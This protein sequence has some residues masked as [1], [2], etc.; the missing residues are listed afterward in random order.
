[1]ETNRMIFSISFAFVALCVTAYA[2]VHYYLKTRHRER[3]ALIEAGLDP[4]AFKASSRLPTF[5]MMVSI[6]LLGIAFAIGTATLLHAIS[7]Y[8]FEE[9]PHF[10]LIAFPFFLAIS[11]IIC[12]RI[13][14]KRV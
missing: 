3:M 2:T 7:G 11:L 12:I 9:Y 13:L 5:L 1:M 10:H 14:K 4:N 6:I 8:T